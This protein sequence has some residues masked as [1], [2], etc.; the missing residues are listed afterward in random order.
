[1]GQKDTQEISG[2]ICDGSLSSL[3][4]GVVAHNL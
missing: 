4:P 3:K 1:M 2:D